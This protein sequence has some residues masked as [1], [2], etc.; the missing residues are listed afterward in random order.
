MTLRFTPLMAL[1]FTLVHATPGWS[2]DA[3]THEI[4]AFVLA[5][6]NKDGHLSRAEFKP[7][8]RA[9]AKAGQPTALNIRFF[10]A[11]DFAFGIVDKN[12]DGLASPEE[13]RTADDGYRTAN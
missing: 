2:F 12:G 4:D 6:R 5:D 10:A 8:V 1:A 7:F 11:Y 3:T 13:L 9:M